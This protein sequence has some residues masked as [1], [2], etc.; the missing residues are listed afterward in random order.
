MPIF[1]SEQL[2][3]RPLAEIFDFFCR[4]AN[5]VLVMPPDFHV[6]LL[7]G[8]E[9]LHLGARFVIQAKRWGV[10]QRI[11]S[12]VTVYEP[13]VRFIDEQREG[14]FRKWIHSHRFEA[15]NGTTR[16]T[17]VI[18][19]E[20]PGG[21]LGLVATA[22]MIERDLKGVFAYRVHKLAELFGGQG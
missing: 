19:F 6:R 2:L 20:P 14:P 13:E 8:P 5:F 16:V 21:L 11:V 10:P 1:E 12:Q 22:G 15:I 7:E 17:D 18:E 9:Q 4:P 3:P